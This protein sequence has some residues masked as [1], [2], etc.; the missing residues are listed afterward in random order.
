MAQLQ[1]SAARAAVA[2]TQGKSTSGLSPQRERLV[3]RLILER[4]GETL[5][6]LSL[7]QIW[8]PRPNSSS[9]VPMWA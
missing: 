2:Q 4:L 1:Q 8:P 5:Q 6:V 3:K 7:D 9:A